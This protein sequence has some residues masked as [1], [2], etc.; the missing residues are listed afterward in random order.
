MD[1]M[2]RFEAEQKVTYYRKKLNEYQKILDNM[3]KVFDIQ[4]FSKP[5]RKYSIGELQALLEVSEK[6]YEW[7]REK[8]NADYNIYDYNLSTPK[9]D[10][11]TLAR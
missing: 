10:N 11:V 5:F 7:S 4:D 2:T 6:A 9:A 8:E 1:I 3:D